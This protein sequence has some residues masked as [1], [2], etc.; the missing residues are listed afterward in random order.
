VGREPGV[1]FGLFD[2]RERCGAFRGVAGLKSGG[3]V[4]T[5]WVPKT[6]DEKGPKYACTLCD[7]VFYE[8]EKHA[9]ERH[10]VAGHSH[11]ELR[12]HSLTAQAPGLLDPYWEGGDVEWQRW[13]DRMRVERPGEEEKWMRTDLDKT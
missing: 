2:L 9:Y 5:I 6:T 11:E 8:D 1:H 3:G 12:E 13:I 4:V 7:K 10:V